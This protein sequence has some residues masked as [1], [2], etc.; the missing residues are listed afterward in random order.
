MTHLSLLDVVILLVYVLASVLFGSWFVFRNRDPESFTRANGRVPS[1][2]V[3]LSLFGTYVSSIS[4]LALPGSAFIR[5]WNSFTLSLTLPVTAWI[6]S[7]YFIPFYRHCG[8]VST[9]CHLEERFGT[10]ARIY[11][12]VCYMLTQ[13]ARMGA[14]MF[15]LALPLH[16][17]L[18]WDV[19]T[20]ILVTGCL[21]T[22]YSMLGGIEGVVWTDA[23]QS[24]VLIIGALACAVMIPLQMPEGPGQLFEIACQHHKFSLGSLSPDLSQATFWVV[25][26]YGITINLQ[27]FGIDQN[28]VQRY[29]TAKSERDAKKS[30]WFSSLLYIP[31][32]A[33]FFFIGTAL[34]AYYTAQPE[35]LTESLRTEIAAG[36]GDSVFPYFIVHGLPTGATG[37]LIAAIFA[38][39]MSTISTSLNGCAT[40][41]LT[42][43][44]QRF[45]HPNASNREQMWVLRLTTV[46]WGVLG[47]G[48]ALAMTLAQKGILDAWWTVSGIFSGGMLGLF[49][50]GFLSRKANNAAALIGTIAGVLAIVW[51]SLS[52]GGLLPESCP[53]SPFQSYLIPVVGTLTILLTGFLVTKHYGCIIIKRK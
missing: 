46:V 48:G 44:Y 35:L 52:L 37:L 42:D 28:F 9:Y 43:F 22:V 19:T 15:L 4:F 1:L 10:W 34:F 30:L 6:A 14:V 31:V 26:I 3:G 53:K 18:G 7:R 23:L 38:A 24:A 29:L 33:F 11:A 25:L 39:A 49:L 40:L 32:S 21:T 13:I 47:M 50:L 16:H 8:T 17:L 12:T 51:M 2:V 36:R 5:D 27:N 20:I 45:F 41:S